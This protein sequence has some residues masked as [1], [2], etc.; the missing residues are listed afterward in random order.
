MNPLQNRY[1]NDDPMK[2]NTLEDLYV[3]ELKDLF[4][5]EQQIVKAL[6]RMAKTA[7]SK[8]LASGFQEHLEQQKS[9]RN[10]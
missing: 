10:V 9:T 3:H 2:L 8:E 5:A 6:P 1:A 7:S 4:S